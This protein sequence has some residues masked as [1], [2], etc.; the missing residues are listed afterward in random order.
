MGSRLLLSTHNV[1]VTA[2]HPSSRS[3]SVTG[4]MEFE[5]IEMDD[6]SSLPPRAPGGVVPRPD[7]GQL[8]TL[9]SSFGVFSTQVPLEETGFDKPSPTSTP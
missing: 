5:T 7:L 6:L 9:A 8:D 4:T 1:A 2:F 3:R